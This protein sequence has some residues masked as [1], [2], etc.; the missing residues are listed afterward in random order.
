MSI[1]VLVVEDHDDLRAMVQ[2]MLTQEGYDVRCAATVDEAVATLNEMP[3]PCL[4]LWD[5]ITLPMNAKLVGQMA[6]RGVHAATIP[7]G[8]TSTGQTTDGSPRITKR[9]TSREA[10][11]SVVRKYCPK[12]EERAPQ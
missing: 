1:S 4:V 10:I 3:T 6:R 8:I 9:L 11:L 12:A 7:V 2:H 5:P